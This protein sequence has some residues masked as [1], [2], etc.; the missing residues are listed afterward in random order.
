MSFGLFGQSTVWQPYNM[1]A[2]TVFGVRYLHAVDTNV[3]WAIPYDGTYPYRTSNWFTRTADGMN[4]NAGK[5][6]PDTL[7]FSP[8]NICGVSD[9]VAYVA[10][11]SKTGTKSGRVFKTTDAGTTWKVVTDTVNMFKT[12][13]NFPNVVHFFDQGRGWVMGDPNGNTSGTGVEFEI[14]RTFDSAA[15]WTRVPDANLPNPL[16]GEWGYTDVYTTYGTGHIWFGT[17]DGRVYFSA[18]SGTTWQVSAVTGMASV[19]GLAFR[20]SV[21]GLCW[22]TTS[23]GANLLMKSNDGGV[24]WT[25]V[26]ANATDIGF[27]HMTAMGMNKF[28]SVGIND[29]GTAFVTSVTT[30]D[31]NTWTVLESG[32][33]NAQRMLKVDGLDSAHAWAGSFSDN[34][35]PKGNYGM[36]KFTMCAMTVS[37]APQNPCM[38]DNVQLFVGGAGGVSYTWTPT[39]SNTSSINVTATSTTVYTVN[40]VGTGCSSMTTFTLNVNALP[41]VIATAAS[42]TICALNPASLSAS[43]ASTYNWTGTGLTSSSG[44]NVSTTNYSS[45]GTYTYVV[46]GTATTGCSNSDTVTV[47][48]LACTGISEVN[49]NIAAVYPNPSKGQLTVDFGKADAGGKITVF[50]MIGNT[51][52]NQNVYSGTSK[53]NIDLSTM[54]KGMYLVTV[55]NHSGST[56]RKL[57]IE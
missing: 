18:D 23:A 9:S 33:T 35:L 42:D 34:T 51:V 45:A 54:P 24:T 11:Y 28:M 4:F 19:G 13:S 14:W 16:A 12:S 40:G 29:G 6:M 22:G 21:N 5:Y 1:N 7:S 25:A 15:T 3:V 55:S 57:I 46:T 41:A 8:S 2:D 43:G 52:H 32:I 38:G 39:G 44:A 53:V 50:D 17:S 56:T 26:P 10:V 37:S 30:D 31:G 20:D 47:T 48:V 49:G 36:N 27:N